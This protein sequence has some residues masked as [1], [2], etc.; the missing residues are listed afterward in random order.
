M[1]LCRQLGID[2]MA[3]SDQLLDSRGAGGLAQR[4]L[5][6][7][8]HSDIHRMTCRAGM[9]KRS[10]AFVVPAE[11]DM[12]RGVFQV[13]YVQADG[14]ALTDTVETADTLFQQV[15]IQR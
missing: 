15:R 14:C 5:Q 7:M 2:R 10:Q 12:L 8:L 13:G 4:S 6:L 1:Q 3:C 9:F 11:H